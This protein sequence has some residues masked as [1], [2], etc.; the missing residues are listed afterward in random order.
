[1]D[2]STLDIL[3]SLYRKYFVQKEILHTTEQYV[4]YIK[5]FDMCERIN[6]GGHR[7]SFFYF[8]EK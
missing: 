7:I 3:D 8:V 2:E 5:L 1:M 4:Q 6:N